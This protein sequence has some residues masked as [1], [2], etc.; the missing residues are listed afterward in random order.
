VD[1]KAHLPWSCVKFGKIDNLKNL[2]AAMNEESYCTHLFSLSSLML[3]YSYPTSPL[4]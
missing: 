3:A 1:P 4:R 2:W